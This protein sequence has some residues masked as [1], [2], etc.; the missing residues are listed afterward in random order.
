MVTMIDDIPD[1]TIYVE[2]L[3]RDDPRRRPPR[4]PIAVEWLTVVE[5]CDFLKIPRS[6]WDKW[7]QKGAAP[8]AVQLP[9][10]QLRIHVEALG[11]WLNERREPS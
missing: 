9:N 4:Q 2:R 7:R 11:D 8:H 1:E 3:P 5:V 10:R 6:T